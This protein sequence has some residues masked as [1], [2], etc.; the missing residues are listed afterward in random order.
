[1]PFVSSEIPFVGFMWIK[2]LMFSYKFCKNFKDSKT[3]SYEINRS[4]IMITK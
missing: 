1:M 4:P 2:N 3:R